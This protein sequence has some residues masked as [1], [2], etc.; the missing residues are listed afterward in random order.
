M[1][2]T[3]LVTR[4]AM[5]SHI[6]M[7]RLFWIDIIPNFT[8]SSQIGVHRNGNWT[9]ILKVAMRVCL[10]SMEH[11]NQSKKGVTSNCKARILCIRNAIQYKSIPLFLRGRQAP[12]EE[13]HWY[14]RRARETKRIQPTQPDS[15]HQTHIHM[16]IS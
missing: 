4:H 7:R 8:T 10:Q 15:V 16:Y 1:Q 9:A 12:T 2:Q 3:H 11:E 6:L 5:P 14:K 13:H